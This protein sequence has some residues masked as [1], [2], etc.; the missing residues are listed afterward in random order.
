MLV[1]AGFFVLFSHMPIVFVWLSQLSFLRHGLTALV[2]AIY[3]NA[4]EPLPCPDNVLYCHY[5]L[6]QTLLEEFGMADTSYWLNCA[7]LVVFFVG[8]RFISYFTLRKKLKSGWRW[9]NISVNISQQTSVSLSVSCCE[10]SDT[11]RE[12]RYIFDVVVS[13]HCVAV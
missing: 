11:L 8:L 5:R 10:C 12:Y 2:V 4:R 7:I 1:L 6:P 9:L 13:V 3:G